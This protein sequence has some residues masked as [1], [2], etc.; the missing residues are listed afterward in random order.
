MDIHESLNEILHSRD[1]FGK[2]FYEHLLEA[3][4]ELQDIFARVNMNR[5]AVVLATALMIVERHYTQATPAIEFYLRYLGTKHKSLG[6]GTD[7]YPKFFAALFHTL[8]RFHGEKWN[9]DLQR[10]WQE[11]IERAKSAMFDGY[12]EHFQV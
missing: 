3:N 7:D 12:V 5:Q 2:M 8:Q 11:A 1:G 10:Q 6:V 4:P 9:A